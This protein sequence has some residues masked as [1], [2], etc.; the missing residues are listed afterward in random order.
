[1]CVKNGRILKINIFVIVILLL[2]I[3]CKENQKLQITEEVS[4]DKR[5]N[6]ILIVADD[7]GYADVGFNGS[8]DITTPQLDELASNGT[9]ATSGYV[10]HPFCGPSRAALLT[11]R[12][13]HTIGSQF[14][15]PANSEV[16]IGKG[17]PLQ[18]TFMS[19]MLQ[20][21]GYTTGAIGK[22]HLG[23]VADYHPNK[24]GFDDF[25]GF[26]GGG[27]KYFPEE[28]TATYNKQKAAGQKVIFDYLKPLEHNGVNVENP[29]EYLTDE[30]SRKAVDFVK[31]TST[32]E[33]PFF[34]YLAYNAPHV[35]LEAKAEDLELFKHIE[36]KD[37]RTYAAMVYA[38]DRGVGELVKA[39][40]AKKEYENTLIVF[41][42]DNGGKLS[43]G[44][45]NYPLRE[46]KGSTAEGGYRVPMF[47][48]WPG[49]ITAGKK[50]DYPISTLDFYPTFATL[51]NTSIPKNKKLDGKDIWQNL[52][53][54]N[55]PRKDEPVFVLRHREGYSDVGVRQNEWKALKTNKNAWKLFNIENDLGESNDLSKEHPEQLKQMVLEAQNWSKTHTE[56]QWFDPEELQKDWE[57]QEMAKFNGTFELEEN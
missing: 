16:N 18:E 51:A 54:G 2:L 37:R 39:L 57:E 34:L 24:R 44:A 28:Y 50:F 47:F 56:P 41:L 3:A 26:L 31:T 55:N 7:L 30:L 46:G 29:T 40:K 35:P 25:Y 38:V 22:W 53:N 14:N 20:N 43:R 13:P 1:M 27:H 17:I 36:D 45:N 5:P 49:A 15:L 48:H 6:I 21:A 8:K 42:S 33:N 52:L 32:D 9:I 11:G 12:Y 19:K 4:T 23:A 10:A